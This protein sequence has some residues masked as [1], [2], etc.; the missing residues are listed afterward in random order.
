VSPETVQTFGV[1]AIGLG[2]MLIGLGGFATYHASQK[3]QHASELQAVRDKAKL[4][5]QILT[6]MLKNRELLD[7]DLQRKTGQQQPAAAARTAEAPPP[8]P[9]YQPAPPP[10]APAYTPPPATGYTPPPADAT[11]PA[12][13]E[14]G[15]PESGS[16]AP[17]PEPPA[18]VSHRFPTAPPPA[19]PQSVTV[20]TAPMPK[21]SPE[22]PQTLEPEGAA[23][24]VSVRQRHAIADALRLHGRHVVT[25]ESSYGDPASREFATELAAAFGEADWTA[26]GIDEHKGLPLASGVTIS[27]ASFPPQPE[28]LVVYEALLSAGIAVTQQLDPKQHNGET[29]VLVGPP[30]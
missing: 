28:T 1:L 7:L 27:A 12:A 3:I 24:Y 14:R 26:K 19:S 30:L 13:D 18:D 5:T 11:P 29:V 15:Q 17:A 6:L 10:P 20:S 16:V 2:F 22:T 8:T 4:D 23:R 25:I 9:Y 21:G